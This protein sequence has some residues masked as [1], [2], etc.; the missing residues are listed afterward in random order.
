MK[1]FHFPKIQWNAI[2]GLW[3]GHVE[4]L[5]VRNDTRFLR[6]MKK[7]MGTRIGRMKRIGFCVVDQDNDECFP[8]NNNGKRLP[9]KPF[10]T[11]RRKAKKR[12][13]D[14]PR[15]QILAFFASLA[16]R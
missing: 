3:L 4:L 6:R 8:Q 12:R 15:F 10:F 16:S 1:V 13:K 14:E 5:L 7:R 2:G 9:Q 11:Q